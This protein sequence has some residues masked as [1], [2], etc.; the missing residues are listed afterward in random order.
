MGNLGATEVGGAV[1]PFC[2]FGQGVCD[3]E[4]EPSEH[5]IVVEQKKKL[6]DSGGNFDSWIIIFAEEFNT[7]LF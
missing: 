3:F 7:A 4:E 5:S 6:D 2:I 1:I